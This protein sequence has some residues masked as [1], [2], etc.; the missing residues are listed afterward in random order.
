M[1]QSFEVGIG[2]RPYR[3]REIIVVMAHH[4]GTVKCLF[5]RITDLT[6]YKEYFLVYLT[7]TFS[8]SVKMFLVCLGREVPTHELSETD[9]IRGA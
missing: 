7:E 8:E 4:Q 5:R 9:N 2:D 3:Y 6:I 1:D